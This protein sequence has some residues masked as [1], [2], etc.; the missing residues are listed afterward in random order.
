[1]ARRL[2]WKRQFIRTFATPHRLVAD[3]MSLSAQ[4]AKDLLHGDRDPVNFEPLVELAGV[5][6]FI[7]GF[8][9]TTVSG[10]SANKDLASTAA[11]N[12]CTATGF[13]LHA[14]ILFLHRIQPKSAIFE[15]VDGLWL[16]GQLDVVVKMMVDAGYC[17]YA[18]RC[19]PVNF[20]H[21]GNRPRVYFLCFRLDLLRAACVDCSSVCQLCASI[22]AVMSE[23]HDMADIDDFLVQDSHSYIQ[24]RK[25]CALEQ[26]ERKR[27]SIGLGSSGGVPKW[28]C[29]HRDRSESCSSSH[30]DDG[31]T[32]TH[33]CFPNLPDRCK[34]LLEHRGIQFPHPTKLVLNVS[35][36]GVT[37]GEAVAPTITPHAIVYLA[38][39]MRICY[40]RDA[41]ALQGLYIPDAG[42]EQLDR[43]ATD[44]QQFDLAGNA[45]NT[46]SFTPA[47]LAC[48]L[49]LAKL[50]CAASVLADADIAELNSDSE[51]NSDDLDWGLAVQS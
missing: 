46:A 37:G 12:I 40:G 36:S 31:L 13:T 29:K 23:G 51:S 15:N 27:N 45:F 49:V 25:K 6:L 8:S 2:A 24:A 39:R 19:T 5:L 9:C 26:V 16:T 18:Y 30:W 11:S 21:P 48:L 42:Y 20:G 10:L 17:V 38:H 34:D 33:P 35:Q 3:I 43:I 4:R 41:L 14:C 32:A 44:A 1:M 7:A 47:A 28:V 50:H 22:Y